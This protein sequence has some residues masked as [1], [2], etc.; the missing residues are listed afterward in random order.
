[1]TSMRIIDICGK[2]MVSLYEICKHSGWS[3]K[4]GKAEVVNNHSKI[5]IIFR[6]AGRKTKSA[7]EAEKDKV[8]EAA[9]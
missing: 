7:T 6:K 5:K 9:S 3:W 4:G 8:F 2:G 1:M